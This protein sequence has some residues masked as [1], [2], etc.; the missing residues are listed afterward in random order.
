MFDNGRM[1]VQPHKGSQMED[2]NL[3][4]LMQ[5]RSGH[6]RK[7]DDEGKDAK[8]RPRPKQGIQKPRGMTN[9]ENTSKI[10]G[11]NE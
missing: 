3:G 9:K 1:T 5:E 2:D 8:G 6:E 10:C 11:K 4:E 7:E